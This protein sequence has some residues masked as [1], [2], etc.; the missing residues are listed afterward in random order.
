MV[1]ET[2]CI[3]PIEDLIAVELVCTNNDCGFVYTLRVEHID[4]LPEQRCPRCKTPWWN[5][6][7]SSRAQQLL[8]MLWSIRENVQDGR[9]QPPQN[10]PLEHPP[11]IKLVF[12]SY[13]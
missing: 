12:P 3:S 10:M 8:K 11:K 4:D 9:G 6:H 13:P 2:R 1:T 7:A 5:R